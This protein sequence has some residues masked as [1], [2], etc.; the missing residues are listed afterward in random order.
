[1]HKVLLVEDD[2]A[3]AAIVRKR[4][5]A[6]PNKCFELTHSV[7]LRSA[8]EHLAEQKFDAVVVINPKCP[9]VF[10]FTVEFVR[11]EARVERVTAK[12]SFAFFHPKHELLR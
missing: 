5:E 8:L 3:S 2:D 4:F 9:Q 7:T 11:A 12:Q 1:M 6:H 10:V